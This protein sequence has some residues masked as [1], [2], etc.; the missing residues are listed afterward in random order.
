MKI[1]P[2]NWSFF[3]IFS[4][5]LCISAF[6][7]FY[8][9]FDSQTDRILSWDEVHYQQAIKQGIAENALETTSATLSQFLEYSYAKFVKDSVLLQKVIQDMP[10]EQEDIFLLRHFHP[11]LPIYIWI[12]CEQLSSKNWIVLSNYLLISLLAFLLYLYLKTYP[13]F[14]FF[15]GLSILFIAPFFHATFQTANFH[16]FF[17]VSSLFFFFQIQK[18]ASNH[19]KIFRQILLSLSIALMILTLETYLVIFLSIGMFYFFLLLS[20]F[21]QKSVPAFSAPPNPPHWGGQGWGRIKER[22]IFK[23]QLFRL[24]KVQDKEQIK[25]DITFIIKIVSLSLLWVFLLNPSFFSTGGSLKSW[26]YYAYRIFFAGN[27]EYQPVSLL[28][29]IKDFFLGHISLTILVLTSLFVFIKNYQRVEGQ[30][31]LMLFCG[32]AYLLFMLPF[33]LYHTYLMPALVLILLASLMIVKDLQNSFAV[34]FILVCSILAEITYR[35][36]TTSFEQIRTKC[37][38][39]KK[40]IQK[41]IQLTQQTQSPIL[42]DANHVFN[43][44]A[45][46][47][48]FKKLRTISA[49]RPKFYERIHYENLNRYKDIQSQTFGA[50]ILLKT[51]NYTVEDF[52]FLT[53]AGYEKITTE[54]YYLFIRK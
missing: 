13:T 50:I 30:T 48:Q 40:E 8:L 35:F 10:N 39:E 22:F 54:N 1:L 33:A 47:T 42:A 43:Y 15:V 7:F 24:P 37:Q 17:C 3:N 46:S 26:A 41:I 45:Q 11:V 4:I 29:T 38:V 12:L 2:T 23:S 25:R 28:T 49:S 31:L 21:Q 6:I 53:R 34:K 20:R 9:L 32:L 27:E 18:F 51:R 19:Q 14:Y 44:Y 16:S 5:I 52:E 36:T